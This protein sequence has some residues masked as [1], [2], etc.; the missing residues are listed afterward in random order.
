MRAINIVE[1]LVWDKMDEV[2]EHKPEMC[3]C[4]KCKSDIAAYALNKLHPRYV[5]SPQGELYARADYLGKDFSTT[6]IEPLS[7][8][9][10]LLC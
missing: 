7:G 3:N 4:N 6:L 2:L 10:S 9:C 5:A 1:K 8:L